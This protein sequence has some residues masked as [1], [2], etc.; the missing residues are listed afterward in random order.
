MLSF[1]L[2]SKTAKVI[3]DLHE[4]GDPSNTPLKSEMDMFNNKLGRDTFN[5]NRSTMFNLGINGQDFVQY[6][7]DRIVEKIDAGQRRKIINGVLLPSTGF[8]K[9]P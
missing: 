4:N 5:A 6:M 9:C 2:D 7:A 8:G 3:T 1:Y